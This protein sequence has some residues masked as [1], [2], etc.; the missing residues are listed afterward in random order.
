MLLMFS[1]PRHQYRP[2]AVSNILKSIENKTVMFYL[3][4]YYALEE[5][6]GGILTRNIKNRIVQTPLLSTSHFKKCIYD[7]VMIM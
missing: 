6:R 3:Q 5:K 1:R 4:P 7:E 2:E